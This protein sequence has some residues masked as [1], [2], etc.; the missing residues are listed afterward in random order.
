MPQTLAIPPAG[1]QRTEVGHFG[2]EAS[3]F[4]R[5]AVK[6]LLAAAVML[7][8]PRFPPVAGVKS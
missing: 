3:R 8:A 7:E 4:G 5:R 6:A 2:T 1:C